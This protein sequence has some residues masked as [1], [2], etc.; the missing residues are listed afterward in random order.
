MHDTWKRALRRKYDDVIDQY[1]R[2]LR[3][4]PDELW[5]E[6]LWEVK[7]DH[8]GVWPVKT[9]DGKSA[10][11]AAERERLLQRY[12]A[13]WNV[14][15][16]AIF[17]IDFYLSG[18]ELRG[19][20]PPQPFLEKDHHAHVVPVRPYTREEL[21]A[22]AGYVR[23]KA[24]ETI[25]ALT[26]ESSAKMLAR[27]AQPFG[28]L[29]LRNVLHAQE[30]AA[31]LSLFLSQR[32]IEPQGGAAAEMGRQALR[33]GVRGRSDKEIDAW[34]KRARGYAF[35]MPL[36]FAGLCASLRPTGAGVIA[37]DVGEAYYV[38]LAQESASFAKEA[39]GKVAATVRMSAQDFLRWVVLD[40]D[41]EDAIA[42]GR[43]VVEGDGRVLRKLLGSA[44]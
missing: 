31:Q 44:G 32:G 21:R 8:F 28:E 5:D 13:F 2:V 42:D 18:G 25:E 15:Y 35:L 39:S 24:R 20:A 11:N 4:C 26:D 7:R 27:M 38:T 16:H 22:Y 17:H 9:A 3:D 6:S 23:P 41:L 30:H 36:V 37:F 43:A 10:L 29:L 14:A 1:E 34:V 19:F 12:S 40:L 33:D